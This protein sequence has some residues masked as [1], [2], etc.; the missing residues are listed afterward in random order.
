MRLDLTRLEIDRD[1]TIGELRIDGEWFCWTLE[2]RVRAAKIK[3]QTAIPT[4]SYEVRIT[5]SQRFG[6]RMPLVVDVPEFAGIR[7][8]PGNS[9]ADTS[10]CILVGGHRQGNRIT[11]SRAA[12]QALMTRLESAGDVTL[13]ITQPA[14][15]PS[16][17]EV[18]RVN[19]SGELVE[20]APAKPQP[21]PETIPEP[22]PLPIV[23][24][25]MDP[26]IPISQNGP[27]AWLLTIASSFA[28]LGGGL[29]GFL[30]QNKYLLAGA[31]AIICIVVI[32]WF[33]RSVILDLQRM[34]LASDP[35][36]YTVK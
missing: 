27:R 25:P 4:G 10:G 14:A 17:G 8:H 11:D 2:D 30:Q 20:P 3:H 24:A 36:R 18:V 34:K 26:P 13:H 31:A 12:Y 16:W 15:W 21:Q 1:A 9:A 35:R 33:V 6:V 19:P 29:V 28:G 7:I 23:S 22:E 5:H 32:C